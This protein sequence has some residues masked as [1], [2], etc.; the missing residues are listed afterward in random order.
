MTAEAGLSETVAIDSAGI[1][2]WHVGAPPDHRAQRAALDRGVDLSGLRA[3]SVTPADFDRFDLILAM[4]RANLEALQRFRPRD[5]R[6]ELRL[7]LDFATDA[8]AREVPDPYYGGEDGFDAAL[9]LIE[10]ASRGLLAHLQSP[11][12]RP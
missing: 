6:A 10:A 12:P 3:R 1:G 8:A 5:S 11:S 4:D 2:D 9:D 7:F